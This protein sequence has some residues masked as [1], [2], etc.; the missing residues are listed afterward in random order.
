M[1]EKK[2]VS[3]SMEYAVKS[4]GSVNPQCCS[5]GV[6]LM[7][8]IAVVALAVDVVVV[9]DYAGAAVAYLAG[10]AYYQGVASGC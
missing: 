1:S 5:P 8:G 2:Y 6:G 7:V 3:P 9:V 10:A 4:N